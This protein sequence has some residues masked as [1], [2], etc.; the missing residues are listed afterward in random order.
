MMALERVGD[1]ASNT[2]KRDEAV[3]SYSTALSLGP[4]VPNTM[5]IKWANL[6]L[7]RGSAD[8]ASG[9]ASKVCS[10]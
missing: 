8:E 9:A 7:K 6:I 2:G 1:E 5:V 3:A 10:P 4:A